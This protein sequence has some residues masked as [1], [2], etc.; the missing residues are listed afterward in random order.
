MNS[1]FSFYSFHF[2][3]NITRT[4]F[5]EMYPAAQGRSQDIATEWEPTCFN[6]DNEEGGKIQHHLFITWVVC[7]FQSISVLIEAFHD[8]PPTGVDVIKFGRL[9]RQLLTNV[10]CLKYV[11]RESRTWKN[12]REKTEGKIKQFGALFGAIT[13][14]FTNTCTHRKSSLTATVYSP[15][16]RQENRCVTLNSAVRMCAMLISYGVFVHHIVAYSTLLL[17]LWHLDLLTIWSD[18]WCCG[19]VCMVFIRKNPRTVRSV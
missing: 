5:R 19:P 1:H 4:H 9:M 7:S 12:T 15:H 10:L 3:W 6:E 13:G 8:L 2:E 14:V 16:Q 11:L 18:V 17:N